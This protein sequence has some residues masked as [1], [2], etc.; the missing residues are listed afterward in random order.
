[1]KASGTVKHDAWTLEE[2]TVDDI[3]QL[4]TWFPEA[5]D[6]AIWGGPSFRYPF[7]RETF[8][9]DIHWGRLAAY[10]LYGA[11][12][13]FGAFGQIYKR[14]ERIHFTGGLNP[15]M[16]GGPAILSDGRVAGVNVATAGNAVGFLVPATY[17]DALLARTTHP[18]FEPAADF[19]DE[20]RDQLWQR[21][22][23]YVADVLA[24]PLETVRLGPFTVP[25][26]PAAFFECRGDTRREED[27]LYGSVG[28]AD[29][30]KA[31]AAHKIELAK[32]QVL[33]DGPI[34][35]LGEQNVAVRLHPQV[36]TTFKVRV[37]KE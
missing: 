5:N 36:K 37:V 30:I 17:V 25:S 19:M 29:I 34:K 3:E 15:G 10:S 7:T 28:V 18:G 24:A 14:D 32:E 6:I 22:E 33:L 23:A 9:E 4:M 26:R 35:E 21:Q 31:A 11:D 20:I 1:M 8:F 16:S 13:S 2:S 27:K 12:G